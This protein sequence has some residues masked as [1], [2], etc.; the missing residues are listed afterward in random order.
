MPG[1]AVA[2]RAQGG[3]YVLNGNGRVSAGGG[4]PGGNGPLFG[5]DIA[6]DIA[7]MPDGGGYV[8]LD[9]WGGVHPFGTAAALPIGQLRA[10]WPSWDIARRVEIT[11]NGQGLA[12]LDGWGG[13]HGAGNAPTM[14]RSWWHGWDIAR[15]LAF[16]PDN[17]GTYVLDGWGG[18]HTAGNAVFGGA[19][20][21]PGWDIA[22]DLDR[23]PG[24]N[25]YAVLSAFGSVHGYN[26]A[27]TASVQGYI[28][29]DA[30]RG[31]LYGTGRYRAVRND[32]VTQTR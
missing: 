8:V 25:G 19:P 18:V 24:G 20:Y 11:S 29:A 31:L 7:V 5:W 10:Y 13:I 2:R 16:T 27:R 14:V 32:G 1:R 9:G 12:V 21:W 17:R 26:G 3:F 4:A 23:Q 6:R 22:R 30:W 15:G 28:Q